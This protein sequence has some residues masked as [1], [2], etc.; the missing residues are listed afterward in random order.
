MSPPE[1]GLNGAALSRGELLATDD[2]LHSRLPTPNACC[3]RRANMAGTWPTE[4]LAAIACS[5][6]LEILYGGDALPME[7]FGRCRNSP[8]KLGFGRN[9]RDQRRTHHTTS[10]RA[11]IQVQFVLRGGFGGTSRQLS[12]VL[13]ALGAFTGG[14]DG[15]IFLPHC[16]LSSLSALSEE[17]TVN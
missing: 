15:N 6:S 10:R 12:E 11:N 5:A 14:R 2:G 9:E 16:L 4:I 17:N 8:R 3:C 13:R 7:I 1:A